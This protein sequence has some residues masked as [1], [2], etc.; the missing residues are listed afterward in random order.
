MH[1]DVFTA[2]LN[3]VGRNIREKL[4]RDI[5][6][7]MGRAISKGILCMS[8]I[9]L[10]ELARAVGLPHV[11]ETFTYLAS[12]FPVEIDHTTS[13]SEERAKFSKGHRVPKVRSERARM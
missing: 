5:H 12:H 10:G 9:T 6:C 2:I 13:E 1:S 8:D 11:Y 4:L 7:V 3:S